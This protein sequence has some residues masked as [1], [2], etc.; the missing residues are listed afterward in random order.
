LD[1][2]ID[3]LK[4]L[5]EDYHLI[6]AGESYGSFAKYES[7]IKEN[8][9]VSRIH[10]FNRYIPDDEVKQFF[11][12]A[13]VCVLPYRSATQSGITAIA[14]HFNLPVIATDVGGLKESITDEID[15]LIVQRAEPH[16]IANAVKSYFRDDREALFRSNLEKSS[17]KKSWKA[18]SDSLIA[19]SK[20]L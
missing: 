19:F 17:G 13:D 9:L 8:G 12:A 1:I 5:S 3:A 6:I 4:D 10:V 15:G 18:F 7:Q 14:N 20:T 2:L 16:S 11:S